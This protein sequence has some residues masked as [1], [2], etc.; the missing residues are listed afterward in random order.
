MSQPDRKA[1]D[2]AVEQFQEDLRRVASDGGDL[3]VLAG[4]IVS[5]ASVR[6]GVGRQLGHVFIALLM[7][8]LCASTGAEDR[9]LTY[10]GMTPV[11][12]ALAAYR[13]DHGAYP[14]DLAALVPKHLAAIPEDL[15]SGGPIRYKRDGAG[16]VLYSV[17]PNGK[18][19]GGRSR[20]DE[21]R[22]EDAGECD[23]VAIRVPA[24]K[25]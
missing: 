22:A 11:V 1:R 4:N 17:G 15:F 2:A 3:G 21:P 16:Y 5:R 20:F 7:P 24:K 14:A 12:F 25:R 18:D 6:A 8:A 9:N 19:D 23:D 13:A 10:Q